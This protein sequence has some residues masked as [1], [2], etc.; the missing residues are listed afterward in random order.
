MCH[1][2]TEKITHTRALAD[3]HVQLH[4]TLQFANALK[5]VSSWKY[6]FAIFEVLTALLLKMNF[7]G[8][9]HIRFVYIELPVHAC[10]PAAIHFLSVLAH[11]S[12]TEC[13]ERSGFYS[14]CIYLLG[15]HRRG[16]TWS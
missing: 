11:R 14:S 6:V 10:C 9:L 4:I 13:C 5:S 7:S 2:T 8:M 16:P 15:F 1:T 3:A 12:S